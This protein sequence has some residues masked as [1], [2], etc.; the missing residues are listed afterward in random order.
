[1]AATPA[2]DGESFTR[3]GTLYPN[4]EDQDS[5]PAKSVP[6]GDS[7]GYDCEFVEAPPAAFLTECPICLHVLREPCLISCPCGQ[8][9][10]R[11]CV[12]QIKKENKPCPLCNLTDFTFMRDHGLERYLGRVAY[13]IFLWGGDTH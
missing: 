3:Q 7:G 5:T 13:R 10:C 8:K 11:E 9:I 2:S 1:M 6:M 4:Q 12:E